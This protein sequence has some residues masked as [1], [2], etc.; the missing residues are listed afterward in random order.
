MTRR[1]LFRLLAAAAVAS[2]AA[3]CGVKG[4]LRPPPEQPRTPFPRQYPREERPL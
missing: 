4:P 1:A 3:A 2:A